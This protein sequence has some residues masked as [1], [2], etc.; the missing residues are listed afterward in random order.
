MGQSWD[1]FI[2]S[3][4]RFTLSGI[5]SLFLGW[6]QDSTAVKIQSIKVGMH[7]RD[8]QQL[9]NFNMDTKEIYLEE[10]SNF[11]NGSNEEEK[12]DNGTIIHEHK[13]D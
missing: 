2:H 10:T 11:D 12:F 8:G 9:S 5:G 6:N 13:D 7:D 4:D 1:G 3:W